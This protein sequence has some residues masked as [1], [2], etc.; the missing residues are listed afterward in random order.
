MWGWIGNDILAAGPSR[1]TI[2][3]KAKQFGQLVRTSAVTRRTGRSH[4]PSLVTERELGV[5]FIGHSSEEWNFD[6]DEEVIQLFTYIMAQ[7]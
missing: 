2:R 6:D 3:R 4:K 1:V 7:R 5:T